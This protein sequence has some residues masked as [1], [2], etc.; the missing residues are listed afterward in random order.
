MACPTE[1]YA[2]PQG[3]G[4]DIGAQKLWYQRVYLP[5]ALRE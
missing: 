2:R 5:L 1:R 3:D 4:V